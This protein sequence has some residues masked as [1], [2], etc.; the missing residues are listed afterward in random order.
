MAFSLSRYLAV[1]FSPHNLQLFKPPYFLFAEWMAVK[2]V[3]GAFCLGIAHLAVVLAMDSGLAQL[4]PDSYRYHAQSILIDGLV[5]ILSLA[6]LYK[7]YSRRI[8][9][10]QFAWCS[11]VHGHMDM[12]APTMGVRRLELALY[13]YRFNDLEEGLQE[14]YHPF[15]YE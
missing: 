4:E 2:M 13:A 5:V 12:P 8:T 6:G 11:D 7:L 15:N 14:R 1:A 10:A 9:T 3:I